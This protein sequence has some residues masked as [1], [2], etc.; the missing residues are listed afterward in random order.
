MAELILILILFVAT[1]GTLIIPTLRGMHRREP[2]R[3]AGAV[4]PRA[5]L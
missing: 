2:F 5:G 3:R 4:G 1:A